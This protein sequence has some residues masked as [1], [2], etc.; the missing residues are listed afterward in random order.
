MCPLLTVVVTP[1]MQ[2]ITSLPHSGFPYL[3]L[4]TCWFPVFQNTCN[5]VIT[6]HVKIQSG[7]ITCF[8]LQTLQRLCSAN[9]IAFHN[10]RIIIFE[11]NVSVYQYISDRLNFSEFTLTILFITSIR[12]LVFRGFNYYQYNI[13]TR[14]IIRE[15]EFFWE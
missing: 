5:P 9:S 15:V 13:P 6:K 1:K 14:L 4:E 8:F 11:W 10:S 3:Y 2:I 7:L 12:D